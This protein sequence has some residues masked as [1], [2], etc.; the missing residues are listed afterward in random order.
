MHHAGFCHCDI[1]PDNILI[2]D[3]FKVKIGDLGEARRETYSSMM[4]GIGKIGY[5]SLNA[6]AGK[7]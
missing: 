2:S 4:E 1:S 3:K 6:E 5:K 7:K